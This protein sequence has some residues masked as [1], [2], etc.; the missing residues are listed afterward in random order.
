MKTFSSIIRTYRFIAEHPLTKSDKYSAFIRW[1]RWQISAAINTYPILFPWVNESRLIIEKGM[2]GATGNLYCGLHEF[3]DMALV[4]HFLRT[5]DTFL[6]IG[7]N[8]GSYTILAGSTGAKCISVEPVP[9]TYTRLLRNI[10]INNYQE[11]I[12]SLNV[13]IGEN[14]GEV[15]F[16]ID[17]DTTNQVVVSD[18]AGDSVKVEVKT[19]DQITTGQNIAMCKIDVEGYEEQVVN[20]AK[21]FMQS[22]DLHVVFLEGDNNAISTL[23]REA[24]FS[25]VSYDPFTRKL[26]LATEDNNK[27]NNLWVKDI[28]FV[29][30][31]CIEAPVTEII[32]QRI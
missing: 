17:Q 32:G 20:G 31:R 26:T 15:I 3:Y 11:N 18:Y 28:S 29:Q 10:A 30:K 2:T 16:S 13:A 19:M 23:M 24:K 6:D 27:N 9:S 8:V 21:E 12:S 4:L 1:F 5:G 7:A 22:E 14:A 25:H